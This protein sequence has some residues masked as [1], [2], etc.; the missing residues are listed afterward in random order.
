MSGRPC[1]LLELFPGAGGGLSLSFSGL[2]G[3]GR[4][5]AGPVSAAQQL[6]SQSGEG[7]WGLGWSREVPCPLMWPSSSA[8]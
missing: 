1:R 8:S 7:R 6:S 5:G 2:G 3:T 4:D